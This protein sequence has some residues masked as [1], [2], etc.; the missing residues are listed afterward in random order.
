MARKIKFKVGDKVR[1][2]VKPEYEGG[3]AYNYNGESGSIVHI[4]LD[5]EW[6]YQV[7]FSDKESTYFSEDEMSLST[8]RKQL[9]FDFMYE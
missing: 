2:C 7:E 6:P 1:V 4:W 8:H 3:V 9:M 5:P